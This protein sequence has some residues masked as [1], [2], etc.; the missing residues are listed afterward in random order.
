MKTEEPSP[1]SLSK[2]TSVT[3]YATDLIT[4]EAVA[5]KVL[6]DENTSSNNTIGERNKPFIHTFTKRV[7]VE[8]DD[9][10]NRR[11][12]RVNPT[13]SVVDSRKKQHTW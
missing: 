6:T 12:V 11:L 9:E 2:E 4:G 10:G 1:I 13:V 5:G 7:I 8:T 3:I